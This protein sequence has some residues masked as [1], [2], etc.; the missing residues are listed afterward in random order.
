MTTVSRRRSV[1]CV[2]LIALILCTPAGVSPTS[3]D[4]Y[5]FEA[6]D[7]GLLSIGGRATYT[8]I[9]PLDASPK[10]YG[11]AQVPTSGSATVFAVKSRSGCFS[12]H[13]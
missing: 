5:F 13:P 7:K 8:Y 2:I 4:S 11:G 3:A 1:R 6:V 9:D 10:W 12:I